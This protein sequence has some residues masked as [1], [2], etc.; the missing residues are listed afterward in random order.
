MTDMPKV[1]LHNSISLDGSLLGFEVDMVTHY[2]IAGKLRS[3]I[4][5]T[6]S[7]T[8]LA[9][10]T[11]FGSPPPERMEDMKR[12]FVK[13]HLPFIV[14]TDSKGSLKG[15]LHGI[16]NAEYFKDAVV[17][18]SESTPRDYIGYLK[19][20]EYRHHVIGKDRVDLRKAMALL[21]SEYGART[22]LVDTGQVL[23]NALLDEGLVT[24]ISLLVHPT[25]VGKEG[26]SMFGSGL[27][28]KD[29]SLKRSESIG[30]GMV[31]TLYEVKG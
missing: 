29:L 19:E 23:G 26:Y 13:D 10:F 22:V 18:I 27:R 3:D 1:V 24:E 17:L 7:R 6:G 5:L 25:I 21:R 31:W 28:R 16:R 8:V 14:V 20:R 2:G 15:L 11:I 9:G 30:N 4:T 12:P